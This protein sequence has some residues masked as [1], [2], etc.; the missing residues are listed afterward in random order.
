MAPCKP[1]VLTFLR[2]FLFRRFNTPFIHPFACAQT[3]RRWYCH[4][5]DT[6][7]N[8]SLS[9]SL[10]SFN[11][12]Y[13]APVFASQVLTEDPGLT[14][15]VRSHSTAPF[16]MIP[17]HNTFLFYFSGVCSFDCNTMTSFSSIPIVLAS[18]A[19]FHLV[20]E[21]STP[22]TT[23]I[24]RAHSPSGA[25]SSFDNLP[26][27][28][29]RRKL[30]WWGNT[31]DHG[32]RGWDM[33]HTTLSSQLFSSTTFCFF[34][35]LFHPSR[36]SSLLKSKDSSRKA[37]MTISSRARPAVEFLPKTTLPFSLL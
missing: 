29:K 17:Q 26:S 34:F 1:S 27:A 23:R 3:C 24:S 16:H 20:A 11:E 12:R 22:T 6:I 18:F 4:T 30:N 10:S 2:L 37:T 9:L 21:D 5:H 19:T 8:I 15:V 35:F 25:D 28:V 14:W 31:T 13:W 32:R 33:L 7:P 36:K